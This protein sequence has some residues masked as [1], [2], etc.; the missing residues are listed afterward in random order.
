MEPSAERPF[1]LCGTMLRHQAQGKGQ[2]FELISVEFD[3]SECVI[4]SFPRTRFAGPVR[5]PGTRLTS[6]IRIDHDDDGPLELVIPVQRASPWETIKNTVG[7]VFAPSERGPRRL[8][9]PRHDA[10]RLD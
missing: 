1:M 6:A 5:P 2:L 3:G 9:N 4:D 10:E 7:K 8:P